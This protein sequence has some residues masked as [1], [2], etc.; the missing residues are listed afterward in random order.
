MML[1]IMCMVVVIRLVSV[2]LFK[3]V[4]VLNG[5]VIKCVRLIEFNK[6]VLQGGRG[7]LL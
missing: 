7:C 4:V 3:V 2:V 1:F 6:Y 5:L